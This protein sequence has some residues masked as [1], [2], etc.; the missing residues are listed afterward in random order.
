VRTVSLFTGIGGLELGFAKAVTSL[1]FVCESDTFASAVLHAR[2]PDV[3]IVPDVRSVDRLGRNVDLLLAGFPCQDVSSVGPKHGLTGTKTS[4]VTVVL[5]LLRRDRVPYVVLENVPFMLHLA[6]GEVLR[7]IL[8]ELERL[9]YDWA[10]RI[11][12]AQSFVP[13]RRRRLFI[14]ATQTGEAAR[15]LLT[16]GSAS[17]E[18]RQ[19]SLAEPIGFYWT[20]GT[21]ATGLSPNSVPALKPGST[22]G[23]P[24]PPAIHFPDGF[25]GT[26]DIRDA[27]RLQGF[28]PGWTKPAEQVGRASHRWRLVGN[29]V[30]VPVARWLARRIAAPPRERTFQHSPFP[31]STFPPAAFG[32]QHGRFAVA[33]SAQLQRPSQE[34]EGFLR[35]ELRPLS[36]RATKGFIERARRGTMRFPDGFLESLDRHSRGVP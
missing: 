33:R 4:L 29:A 25:L 9:H 1:K 7:H 16:H 6:N 27:E 22:I 21:Y 12:D 5:D 2:F 28:S 14:V 10:Y 19:L 20:E 8:A 35:F 23:I 11:V 30:A 15:I 17:S 26:P 24:S 34:L 36:A 32:D 13:Q 3:P 31:T 18:P